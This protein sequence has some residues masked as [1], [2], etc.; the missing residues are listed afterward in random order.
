M[1]TDHKLLLGLFEQL[2]YLSREA[3]GWAAGAQKE[4][5][6]LGSFVMLVS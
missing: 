1:H 3:A 2:C 4:T 5:T 6:L